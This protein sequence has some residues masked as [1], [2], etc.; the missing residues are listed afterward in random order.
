MKNTFLI[1]LSFISISIFAQNTETLY[2]SGT[3]LGNEKEWRFYC[4]AGMNSKNGVRSKFLH[5]GKSRVL[6]NTP[7]AGGTKPD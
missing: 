5:N 1:I 6:A 3:G 7:T 2:L 4:S